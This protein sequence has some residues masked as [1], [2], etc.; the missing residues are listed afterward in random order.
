LL[1]RHLILSVSR[2]ERGFGV[3]ER[4]SIAVLID[5]EEHVAL[6]DELIVP[7][8]NIINVTGNVWRNC[9]HIGAD[10]GVSG[11]WRIEVV[12]RHI[13]AEQTS[14]NEQ[15]ESKQHTYDSLHWH[16]LSGWS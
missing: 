13:V 4:E 5:D 14:R 11:P 2:R 12:A 15:D 9:S 10:A 8:A 16:L 1:E 3:C 6:V 7:H